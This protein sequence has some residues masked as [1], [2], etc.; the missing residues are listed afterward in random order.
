MRGVQSRS[1]DGIGH[2]VILHTSIGRLHRAGSASRL[3]VVL[4]R[5]H[6]TPNF[7]RINHIR[8]IAVILR[9][10]IVAFKVDNA[11]VQ[12]TRSR[13]KIPMRPQ[14]RTQITEIGP[15]VWVARVVNVIVNDGD[16]TAGNGGGSRE[17][18]CG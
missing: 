3:D 17:S 16:S 14:I 8:I 5:S 6:H 4:K 15:S 10:H 12:H 11:Y 13:I 2:C 9:V 1:R 18:L 7:N